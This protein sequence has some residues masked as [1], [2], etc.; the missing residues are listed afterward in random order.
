MV[1]HY[2]RARNGLTITNLQFSAS[3][4]IVGTNSIDNVSASSTTAA[5]DTL[6]FEFNMGEDNVQDDLGY[7]ENSGKSLVKILNFKTGTDKLSTDHQRGTDATA[8]G[9]TTAASIIG[10]ALGATI[11][12]S[13]V[14][15]GNAT[16]LFTYNGDTFFIGAADTN[17]LDTTFSDGETVFQ[18]VGTTDIVAGDIIAID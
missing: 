16:A 5:G 12:S 4:T 10:G 2:A 18:F 14:S 17:A 9:T 7:N 15:D 13:D 11:S 8:I 1:A 3:G 6:K